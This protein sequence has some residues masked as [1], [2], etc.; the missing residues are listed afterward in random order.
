MQNREWR[1]R[2]AIQTHLPDVVY[3][4][5]DGIVTTLVVIAGVTGA[6]LPPRVILI[7]GIANLLADGF[8]M[9]TSSFLSARSTLVAESRPSFADALRNG[10]ATFAA[11][12][13]AGFVPLAVY[14]APVPGEWRFT[15]ASSL[16]AIALFVV[17]AGR[18]AFSDR[19]WPTAGLEMLIFGSI[20]AAVAF[21]VGHGASL[22]IG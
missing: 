14:L 8:S 21:A 19:P 5:N 9:G 18:A 11:F 20:A 2:S 1:L 13:L 6:A 22:V 10:R 3:G 7:L 17:G 12:V 15:V 16:A 4:A